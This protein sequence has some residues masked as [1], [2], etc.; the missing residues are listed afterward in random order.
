MAANTYN[1]DLEDPRTKQ[2]TAYKICQDNA[3]AARQRYVQTVPH[4]GA[5]IQQIL[6]CMRERLGQNMAHVPVAI[7]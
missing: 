2:H 6:A 5:T 3:I 1:Y 7:A 4:A